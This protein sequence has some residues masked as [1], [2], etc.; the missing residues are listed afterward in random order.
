MFLILNLIRVKI[1]V[2]RSTG[3][4]AAVKIIAKAS[5]NDVKSQ[6]RSSLDK[7]MGIHSLV[8]HENIIQLY[9]IFED[10][11]SMYLVLEYAAG[12]EL[13]NRIAPDIG[14]EEELAHMYFVQLCA[15]MV[16][17]YVIF[18]MRC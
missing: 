16:W 13:F 17:H 9:S 1:A 8:R 6:E 7:E 10:F 2:N 12:G 3:K 5:F 15:G 18:S 4:L 11:E 14:V